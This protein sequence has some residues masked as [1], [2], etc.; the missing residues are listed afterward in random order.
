LTDRVEQ[1]IE[2]AERLRKRG[3][4]RGAIDLL[5]EANRAERDAALEVALVEQRLAAARIH[6]AE[7]PVPREHVA[8]E[9]DGGELFE[10]GPEDLSVDA[11]RTGLARS[12]CLLVRGLVPPDRAAAL[13]AGIDSALANF[14][15]WQYDR[16]AVDRGWYTPRRI[17]DRA[18]SG[19]GLSRKLNRQMGALWTI[20]SPRMVFELLELVDDVGLG[21]LMTEHL[22]ERP[23]LSA[24]KST[25]RRVPA[26]DL[27]P[28]WHQDGAFL[29][30]TIGSFNFWVTLTACGRDAPGLD[31]VPK[32]F[33]RVLPTGE[34][35]IFDWSLAHETVL[36][37]AGDTP[38]LRP[39]FE[40]GDAL[41]FDHRLVHRTASSA[42]MPHERYAIESWFF[43]P[44]AYPDDQVPLLY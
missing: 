30:D 22:G 19:D 39:E 33:D 40:A 34:G 26:E 2:E 32:R 4:A 7:A 42:A 6:R 17:L 29:G 15:R 3:D 36:A 10:I 37:A 24:N 41:L 1:T 16:P 23:F 18:G 25:L 20:F 5:T 28:G 21:A 27:L 44:S 9:G 31:L 12:G 11:Y 38:I 43:A 35:A 8:P 13:A 14:D